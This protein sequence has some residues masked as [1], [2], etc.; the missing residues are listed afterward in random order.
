MRLLFRHAPAACL[1]C[2]LAVPLASLPSGPAAAQTLRERLA[3]RAAAAADLVAETLVTEGRE[4]SWYI[5]VPPALAGAQ[6]LA[7]VLVF[8]GG[9]GDGR[10]AAAASRMAAAA[11]AQGFVAVFPD[12]PGAQ[13]NDGRAETATGIDDVGFVR[14]L[15]GDLALRHGVDTGRIFIAGI[16]NGGMFVQRLACDAPDA[17]RAGAV[18]AAAMPADLAPV[19]APTRARPLIFLTGTEDRLMPLEGG[20]I[21][22]LPL[23]GIG[24]GGTVLSLAGT[25]AFW[26]DR[27]T[28]ASAG[29]PAALPDIA[30]DGTTVTRRDATGCADGAELTFLAIAGGGHNWPGSG[31]ESRLTGTVSADIDGTTEILA[32]FARHGL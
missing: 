28:C 7:A 27:F 18:V 11:E 9:E 32:F 30:D 26:T 13:W 20:E 19:C 22:S 21:P 14:A 17:F 31:T 1:A 12:S 25:Q 5:H 3:A 10:D 29:T 24:L 16:S 6:G 2:A 15:I 4:R 8:H 23:L